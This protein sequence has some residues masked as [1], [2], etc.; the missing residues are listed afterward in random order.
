MKTVTRR[1]LNLRFFLALAFMALLSSA[2][3]LAA[4]NI[5]LA[6]GV[7][8][9][10][11]NLSGRQRMLTARIMAAFVEEAAAVYERRGLF[12]TRF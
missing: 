3:F 11:V 5:Y 10:A 8:S 2:S 6:S 1:A 7:S 4:A 12:N 9:N